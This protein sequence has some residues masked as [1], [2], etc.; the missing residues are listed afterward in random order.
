MLAGAMIPNI[1]GELP[2]KIVD[3]LTVFARLPK[4]KGRFLFAP[5]PLIQLV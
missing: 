3:W 2:V 5:K 4:V 1:L